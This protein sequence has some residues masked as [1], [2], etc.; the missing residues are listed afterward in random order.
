[1]GLGGRAWLDWRQGILVTAALGVS[2]GVGDFIG[3][4]I[5]SWIAR[6]RPCQVLLDVHELA[7]CGKM[8]SLPSNHAVNAAT[9]A[10]LL[11]VLFPSTRWVVGALLVLG[12]ISRV[13]LG[14]HYP[15]DVLAGWC[16]GG[17]LGTT[18]GY[19]IAKSPW[20]TT[21]PK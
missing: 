21:P 7:G 17:L 9:T 10:A 6:P 1:M 16:L 14:A 15:T 11:W 5:K 4:Q 2:V 19:L 8:F 12:G 3:T 20:Q 18:V 13:Y